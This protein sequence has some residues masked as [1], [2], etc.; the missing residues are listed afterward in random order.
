ML[1]D[2]GSECSR[3]NTSSLHEYPDTCCLVSL[4]QNL[5]WLNKNWR[6]WQ[7]GCGPGCSFQTDTTTEPQ[8]G[9][10][11]VAT[12][13]RPALPE[14][15]RRRRHLQG[16]SKRVGTREST[17]R[18]AHSSLSPRAVKVYLHPD[19]A[20][21]FT[22]PLAEAK[23][24]W[25]PNMLARLQRRRA[26]G[27]RLTFVMERV[28]GSYPHHS[29]HGLARAVNHLVVGESDVELLKLPHGSALRVSEERRDDAAPSPAASRQLPRVTVTSRSHTVVEGGEWRR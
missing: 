10:W 7:G 15:Q 5:F 26:A 4:K 14:R 21:R 11:N 1:R 18:C 9:G 24:R 16:V 6:K 2:E 17:P 22:E 13:A 20:A 23:N 19:S 27:Q 3:E 8:Q 25:H 28:G 29:A 12:T